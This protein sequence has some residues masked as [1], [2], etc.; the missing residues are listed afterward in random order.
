MNETALFLALPVII[1]ASFAFDVY[2]ARLAYRA[3]RDHPEFFATT[4]WAASRSSQEWALASW[5]FAFYPR[6]SLPASLR[7]AAN[8]MAAWH[9]L[10]VLYAVVLA[11]VYL[12]PSVRG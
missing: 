11:W 4:R 2:A 7:R 1:A 9:V 8:L 10:S 6:A 5:R 12:G 3:A